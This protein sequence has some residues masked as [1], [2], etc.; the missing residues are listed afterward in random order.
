MKNHKCVAERINITTEYTLPLSEHKG[1]LVTKDQFTV[2]PQV[3][4]SHYT[5]FFL[6]VP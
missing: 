1:L 3:K 2:V 4:Q 5:G 6:N